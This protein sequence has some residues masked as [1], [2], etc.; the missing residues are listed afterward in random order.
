V[1][2]DSALVQKCA[3]PVDIGDKALPQA[4]LE[5]LWITDRARLL[6]CIQR[7]IALVDFYGDRDAGLSGAGS[8]AVKK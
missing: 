1:K 6:A 4:R 8:K 5:Q 2:P 7:H 3:G